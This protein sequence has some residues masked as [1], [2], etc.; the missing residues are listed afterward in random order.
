MTADAFKAATN[1][2]FSEVK[3]GQFVI[4]FASLNNPPAL[5]ALTLAAFQALEAKLLEWHSR[6]DVACVIL[7]AESA[8]AFCAGG[9]VKALVAALNSSPSIDIAAEFFLHEYFVD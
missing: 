4:G 9:D 3:S 1:L 8:R 5:N 6:P 2:D 7:H